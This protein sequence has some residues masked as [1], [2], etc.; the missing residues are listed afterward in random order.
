MTAPATAAAPA[1][2]A[3]VAEAPAAAPVAAPAAAAPA[4]A[5]PV[6]LPPSYGSI[7]AVP[8]IGTITSAAGGGIADNHFGKPLLIRIV[9][10][11]ERNSRYGEGKVVAPVIDYIALDPA[12][13]EFAEVRGVTVMQKNIRND[14]VAAHR[15]GLDA[16]TGVAT[17]LPTDKDNPAKVLRPLADDNAGGY[18]AQTATGYLVG[19]ATDTFGWWSAA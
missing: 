19:A 5:A 2:A 7:G 10:V 11:V 13:G 16:V 1:A 18:G 15:R 12:T 6:G 4:P 14:L 3:P 9:N 8:Q 17:L